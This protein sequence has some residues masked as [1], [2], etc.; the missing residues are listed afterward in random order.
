MRKIKFR[1]WDMLN[2]TM[3]RNP[4]NGKI[5]GLNDIFANTGDWSYMQYTGLNE[6]NSKE[7]YEDDII[8]NFNFENPYFRSV[9]VCYLGAFGYVSDGDFITFAHNSNFD[10]VNG[11][12]EKIEVIGNIHENPELIELEPQGEEQGEIK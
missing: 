9:V 10:W 8:A 2:K 7:I 11:K 5:G 1:A 6:K 3:Y 4:F 12:S